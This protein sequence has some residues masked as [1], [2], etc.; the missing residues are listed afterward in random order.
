MP[1][2]GGFSNKE[3]LI[4]CSN[5]DPIDRFNLAT[6]L[7]LSQARTWISTVICSGLF[8]FNDLMLE[9]ILHFVDIDGIVDL[10]IKTFCSS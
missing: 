4:H 1:V 7:C 5:L 10:S 2:I 6:F 8:M 9:M 3:Y